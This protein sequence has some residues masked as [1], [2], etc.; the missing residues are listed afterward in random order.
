[1]A[2]R[3]A[4]FLTE[5]PEDSPKLSRLKEIVKEAVENDRKVLVFSYFLKVLDMVDSALGELSVGILN[6]SVPPANRQLL[7]DRFSARDEPGVLVSQVVAGGH[8]LNIQAASVV[9]LTEPQWKPS[10]EE[11]A[12]ARCY[13]MG[14]VRPV[15]VHRLLAED[16]VDEYMVDI[17]RGKIELFDA[18]ARESTMKDAAP[19]AVDTSAEASEASSATEASDNTEASGDGEA[20]GESSAE[21]VSERK[22]EKQIIEHER[23]RLGLDELDEDA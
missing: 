13:R 10:T 9:I 12:I 19:E 22:L 15:E 23:H 2:M 4:T 16:C 8:G 21:A 7:V 1:M 17:L 6:G 5:N 20:G 11:Q 18:Y 3:Q 14:Q